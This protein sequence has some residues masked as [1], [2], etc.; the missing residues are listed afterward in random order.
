MDDVGDDNLVEIDDVSLVWG[1]FE[2]CGGYVNLLW[3]V[4]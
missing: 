2:F 4:F 3:I 1:L